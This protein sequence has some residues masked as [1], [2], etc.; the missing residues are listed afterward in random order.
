M[1]GF[2]HDPGRFSS[3]IDAST[4]PDEPAYPDKRRTALALLALGS[5]VVQTSMSQAPADL[6]SSVYE[7]EVARLD[8]TLVSLAEYRNQVL[9]VVNVAS[10]CGFTPQYEA[11]EALYRQHRDEGLVVLGFPC[12]QF[13]KQEPGAPEEIMKFCSTTYDVTFPLFAK[14]EVN[15][16]RTHPLYRWLKSR[17][18]GLLGSESIKWNFTKFLLDRRGNVVDRY[19]PAT[20]PASLENE[21]VRLLAVSAP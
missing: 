15:G 21:I 5:D 17:A 4:E 19:A 16:E 2:T 10:R 11:L 20:D 18:K 12:N 9:L 13:G 6:P 1:H 8:G 14:L 7:I 3:G